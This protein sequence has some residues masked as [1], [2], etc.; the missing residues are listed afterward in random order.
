M[1]ASVKRTLRRYQ[2]EGRFPVLTSALATVWHQSKNARDYLNFGDVRKA[3]AAR[4]GLPPAGLDAASRVAFVM[5]NFH[6]AISPIQNRAEITR[7]IEVVTERK[8][9]AVLEIGAAK[10]GALPAVSGGA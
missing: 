9:R 8:P 5:E 2:A 10:G 7:L 1:L 4:P 3:L 6:G